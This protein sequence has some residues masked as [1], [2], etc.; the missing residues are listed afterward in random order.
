MLVV[1]EDAR[2]VGRR[3]LGVLRFAAKLDPLLVATQRPAVIERPE[4]AQEGADIPYETAVVRIIGEVVNGMVEPSTAPP[5]PRS[6]VFVVES[7]QDI[8]LDLG[9]GLAIGVHKYSDV[10][11]PMIADALRYHIAVVGT[12]GTGKSRLVKALIDEVIKKTGWSV[13]V[14]DHTGVDYAPYWPDKTVDASSIV[15]DID[16]I[17]EDLKVAVGTIENLIEDYVPIAILRYV[18]CRSSHDL[19]QQIEELFGVPKAS[20]RGRSENVK[21]ELAGVSRNLVKN[22]IIKVSSNKLWSATEFANVIAETASMLGARTPTP[23]KLAL[24]ITLFGE[25]YVKRLNRMSMKVD[26][27][28]ERARRDRVVVIDLSSIE[29]EARRVIVKRVLERL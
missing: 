13:I 12:T 21:V 24:Y 25:H 8:S 26:E 29:T 14:F 18:A 22:L 23:Q 16:T 4:I 28:V 17:T 11:I 9:K 6:R 27:V 19:C 2:F 10:E 5:T 20:G 7:P 15:L 1:V 3:Y